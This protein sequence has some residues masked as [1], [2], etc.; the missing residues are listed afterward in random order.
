MKRILLLGTG[1]TIACKRTEDGLK[2]VILF[3]VFPDGPGDGQPVVR[4]NVGAVN[5]EGLHPFNLAE[6]PASRHIGQ[7]F[8]ECDEGL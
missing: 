5:E 8:P 2:P 7:N 3:V 6:I 4:L 1:G